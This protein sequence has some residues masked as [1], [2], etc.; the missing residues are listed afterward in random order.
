MRSGNRL[1]KVIRSIIDVLNVLVGIAVVVLA[2]LTFI[3]TTQ[4]M[5]MFPIIFLAGAVMNLLTGIKYLLT[6]RM[7]SGIVVIVFGI[8]LSAV[9]FFSYYAIGGL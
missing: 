9:S 3:N 5:W 4:N 2:V 8:F 6:E 7:I 1:H